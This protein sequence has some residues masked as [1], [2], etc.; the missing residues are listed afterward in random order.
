[1]PP[2]FWAWAAGG[3]AAAM[4]RPPAAPAARADTEARTRRMGASSARGGDDITSFYG[5][6]GAKA[7]PRAGG[8]QD[9]LAELVALGLAH[10]VAG[11]LVGPGEV[12]GRQARALRQV[13]GKAL[14]VE[15]GVGDHRQPAAVDAGGVGDGEGGG[16]EHPGMLE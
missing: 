9:G 2:A 11:D 13:L 4:T 5:R 8:R 10:G 3:A 7:S 12:M 14:A 15:A 6:A 16:V 1:M